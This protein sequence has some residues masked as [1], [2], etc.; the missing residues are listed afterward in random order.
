MAL[1]CSDR[2]QGSYFASYILQRIEHNKN[3]LGAITGQTGS[4][5]S[6]SAL[7]LGEM[8]DPDF[9]V[10]NICFSPKEFMDLVNGKT[11]QLKRGSVIVFDEIQ[12]SM[13][14]LE[15]QS[16][17]AKVL[18]YVFQTFRHRN[19]ILFM[20]SPHFSFINA[21][22]RKLF[23][24]RMETVSID[25]NQKV[26]TIKPMLIQV[27]QKTGDVYE[28][29]LRVHTPE[30]GI[31]PLKHMKIALPS[32]ALLK[33]YEEKKDQFGK[34]LNESIGRD[35]QRLEER[36]HGNTH[37]PLTAIQESIVEHLLENK[38]VAEAAK[39]MGRSETYIYDQMS[40]I[41]KKGIQFKA[42]KNGSRI[43]Y[44]DIIGYVQS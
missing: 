12:V 11:K 21:S 35:L 17:Q 26:C 8:L 24:A 36:S 2:G 6:Y 13:S 16:I 10:L 40:L 34:D 20:T 28:K 4:G 33:A 41:Q 27:N 9:S 22:L 7:R 14:H 3:F 5:K 38:T 1:V 19:F 39:A 43:Q 29:Y 23:H 37:K 31:V 25:P 32:G 30:Q 42:V 15:Y 18:N 44:Y